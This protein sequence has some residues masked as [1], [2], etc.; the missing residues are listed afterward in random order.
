METTAG[1]SIVRRVRDGR[2][3]VIGGGLSSSAAGQRRV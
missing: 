1:L 3:A 2:G